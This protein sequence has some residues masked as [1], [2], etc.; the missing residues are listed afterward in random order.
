MSVTNTQIC[1]IIDRISE[2]YQKNI[3]NRYIRMSFSELSVE[4]RTL[5]KIENFT[6]TADYAQ[7]Q[8]YGF[9]EIYDSIYAFAILIKKLRHEVAPNLRLMYNRYKPI[10]MEK[11]MMDMTIAN[12]QD[13][14]SLLADMINE[15]YM[16]TI[17]LDKLEARKVPPI[18]SRMPKLKEVGK[19]LV[20]E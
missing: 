20:N 1:N 4:Q 9:D 16:R 8:G 12:F 7:M 14:L 18:Y 3:A 13:N 15:L 2:H 6:K 10:G 19:M 5:D 17:E 11:I